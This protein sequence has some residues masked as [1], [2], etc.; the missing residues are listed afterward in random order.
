MQS[1]TL[2]QISPE[3]LTQMIVEAIAAHLQSEVKP[4]ESELISR[5][6]VCQLLHFNKT[7][8]LKHTKSG[9]LK[10]YGIG[11]RVLYRREEVLQS[12]TTLK[13]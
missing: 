13:R 8:L 7:T 10:S 5:D 1:S 3:A 11:G 4:V 6:E 9:K 2:I 12:I